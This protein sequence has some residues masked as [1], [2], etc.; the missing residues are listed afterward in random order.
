LLK[1][2]DG[3]FIHHEQETP[4]IS[5]CNLYCLIGVVCVFA[6]HRS[7]VSSKEYVVTQPTASARRAAYQHNFRG[8]TALPSMA[9]YLTA[10]RSL[11]SIRGS[12]G[13]QQRLFLPLKYFFG[14]LK[15]FLEDKVSLVF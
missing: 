11:S 10:Y 2:L 1:E 5:C 13:A 6:V 8:P 9:H 3:T 15:K 12:V 4:T 14:A 7:A